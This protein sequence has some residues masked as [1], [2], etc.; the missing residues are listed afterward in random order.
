MGIAS[1]SA[2]RN[3]MAGLIEKLQ[4]EKA[5]QAEQAEKDEQAESERVQAALLEHLVAEA[6]IA[7]LEA[8]HTSATDL[9]HAHVREVEAKNNSLKSEFAR[10]QASH[11]ALQRSHEQVDAERA[12]YY[13]LLKDSL[14][15]KATVLESSMQTTADRNRIAASLA[16]AE[17]DI[18][19]LKSSLRDQSDTNDQ[20]REENANLRTLIAV[21]HTEIDTLKTQNAAQERE[22]GTLK[23]RITTQ[24][25]EIV[26]LKKRT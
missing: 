18:E 19:D 7:Q 25:A 26:E 23:T 1:E 10:V 12:H 17:R 6:K 3:T 2:S 16:Q 4:A 5:A 8:R 9:L 22:I 13:S 14:E 24:Q 15:H 21:R 20:L 11:G